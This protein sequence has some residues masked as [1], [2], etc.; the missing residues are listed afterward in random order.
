MEKNINNLTTNIYDNNKYNSNNILKLKINLDN[1]NIPEFR[2]PQYYESWIWEGDKSILPYKWIDLIKD[3]KIKIKELDSNTNL[4]N[5]LK[6]NYYKN[7]DFDEK[8]FFF[9]TY[10]SQTAGCAYLDKNNTIKF[11]IVSKNHQ[12]KKIEHSLITR[13]IKRSIE[14]FDEMEKNGKN[15]NNLNRQFEIFV[16]L[17]T[18]NI[19][20]NFFEELGFIKE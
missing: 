7:S 5:F 8:S 12:N 17:E 14:K 4:D 19:E 2:N 15:I 6:K 9:I 18:T 3:S 11:L 16:D 20:E 10:R 1:S 13:A